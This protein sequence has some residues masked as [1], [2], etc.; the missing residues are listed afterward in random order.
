[1]LDPLYYLRFALAL[2]A[3][4][5]LIA[6]LAWVLRRTNLGRAATGQHGRLSVVDSAAIDPRRRLVLIRR[7]GVEHL[8]LLGA[9]GELVIETGIRP[10][11][12]GKDSA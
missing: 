7:D 2:G 6:G 1:V 5:A 10:G 9:S 4:L 12:A 11:A 8:L 3:V